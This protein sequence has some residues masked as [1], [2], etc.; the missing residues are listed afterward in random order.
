MHQMLSRY[1][2]VS[3]VALLVKKTPANAGDKI[4]GFDP[5][6]GKIPRKRAWQPTL[7]C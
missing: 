1:F 5:W 2:R 3:W 6:V 7:V 4:H